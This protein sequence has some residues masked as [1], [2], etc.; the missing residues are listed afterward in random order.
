[1]GKNVYRPNVTTYLKATKAVCPR[2]GK[3]HL[4]QLFWTGRGQPKIF[5]FLCALQ[6]DAIVT[7][8]YGHNN[9]V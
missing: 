8:M 1:M 7:E 3:E 2:C 4:V 5:C 9:Y 6:K